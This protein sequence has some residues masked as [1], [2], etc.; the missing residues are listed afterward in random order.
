MFPLGGC[1]GGVGATRL[2]EE[3]ER[4]VPG[5]AGDDKLRRGLHAGGGLVLVELG[6]GVALGRGGV[7]GFGGGL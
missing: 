3:V 5:D 1:E 4:V 2:D 6:G 7:G